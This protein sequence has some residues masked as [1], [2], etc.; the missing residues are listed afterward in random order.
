MI[1]VIRKGPLRMLGSSFYPEAGKK[2]SI[3]V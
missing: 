2:I 3:P 1:T